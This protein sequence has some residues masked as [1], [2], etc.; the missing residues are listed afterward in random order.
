[1]CGKNSKIKTIKNLV[2]KM[3]LMRTQYLRTIKTKNTANLVDKLVIK[4]DIG[5]N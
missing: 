2:E 4:L 3:S 5:G 1:L